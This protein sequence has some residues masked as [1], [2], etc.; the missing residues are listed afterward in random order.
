M[1]LCPTNRAQSS[2][3]EVSW[4]DGRGV[5]IVYLLFFATLHVFLVSLPIV[6]VPMAWT[7]TNIFH[8]LAHLYFLHWVCEGSDDKCDRFTQWEQ[9]NDGQQ[10]TASRK[11]LT[12]VP[13][14]V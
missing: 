2:N 12:A 11:F 4:W 5:W 9:I 10:F 14:I 6:S 3:P 1:L 13:I 7:I 8:N